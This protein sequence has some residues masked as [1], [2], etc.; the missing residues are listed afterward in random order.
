GVY[1]KDSLKKYK[2]KLFSRSLT[3]KPGQLYNSRQQ[4][5][6]L[7]RL[8]GLGTFKFVKNR[9]EK[10]LS[11]PDSNWLNVYYYLTPAPKKSLQAQI[12]GFAKDNNYMGSQLSVNWR[13]RNTFRG[14][15]HLEIK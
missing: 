9:F 15:E 12:D 7:N 3:Y 13:N 2:S 11:S 1:V 4:N 8:I 14:A 5:A 10:D 6:S